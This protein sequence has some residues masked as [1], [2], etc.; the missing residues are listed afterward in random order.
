MQYRYHPS[1]STL[2]T[3]NP[4][5]TLNLPH[6][7]SHSHHSSHPSHSSHPRPPHPRPLILILLNH[8]HTIT[9]SKTLNLAYTFPTNTV[10]TSILQAGSKRNPIRSTHPAGLSHDMTSYPTHPQ[11]HAAGTYNYHDLEAV[12]IYDKE[13]DELYN[14][15]AEAQEGM[16]MRGGWGGERRRR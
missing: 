5:P 13:N 15:C 7:S 6:H 8:S 12:F 1:R 3:H 9:I 11:I 2:H 4:P 14:T 10:S 16:Y